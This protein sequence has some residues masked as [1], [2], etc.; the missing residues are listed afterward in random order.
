[1]MKTKRLIGNFSL[2]SVLSL[3]MAIA[4]ENLDTD[5][6]PLLSSSET[7]N[8][9]QAQIEEIEA[10][11]NAFN[12]ILG[13]LYFDL[14]TQFSGAQIHDEAILSLQNEGIPTASSGYELVRP[15]YY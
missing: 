8:I 14:S 10:T 6:S 3:N 1:M 5:L 2:L 13:V 12:P 7:T 15:V 11:E 4:Q 9:L